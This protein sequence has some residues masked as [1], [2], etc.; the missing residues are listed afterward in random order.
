MMDKVNM[1]RK[2]IN[3][4]DIFCPHCGDLIKVRVIL[5]SRWTNGET[6]VYVDGGLTQQ[7]KCTGYKA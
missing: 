2:Q 7:H 1:L 6:H 3:E 5:H 4:T